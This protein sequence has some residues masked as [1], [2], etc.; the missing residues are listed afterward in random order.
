MEATLG[1]ATQAHCADMATDPHGHAGPETRVAQDTSAHSARYP[2]HGDHPPESNSNSESNFESVCER[3]CALVQTPPSVE[4]TVVAAAPIR[5][6][7]D[8]VDVVFCSYSPEIP[9][10]PPI[11]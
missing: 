5:P 4:T 7:I 3:A 6:S 1:P 11:V 2:A 9:T 8:R 10:P